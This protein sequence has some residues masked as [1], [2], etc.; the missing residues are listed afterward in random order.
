VLLGSRTAPQPD[1]AVLKPSPDDYTEHRPEPADVLLLIEVTDSSQHY[2]R[3]VKSELY[4]GAG[5][6]E[7]WLV[8]LRQ[9]AI[10]VRRAP[11]ATGYQETSLAKPGD[12]IR[13]LAFPD[14]DFPVAGVLP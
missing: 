13:P 10:E 11:T 5:I 9:G 7:Y 2:T 1:F 3:R 14:V 12:L 8:D 6:P 4:A